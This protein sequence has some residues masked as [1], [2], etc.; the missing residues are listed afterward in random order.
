[1]KST[2]RNFTTA[3]FAWLVSTLLLFAYISIHREG[4]FAES[5]EYFLIFIII[6]CMSVCSVIAFIGLLFLSLLSN[7]FNWSEGKDYLAKI[8]F[9]ASLYLPLYFLTKEFQLNEFWYWSLAGTLAVITFD[10]KHLFTK[11]FSIKN[12]QIQTQ[13]IN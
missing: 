2:I 9:S 12:K 3:F 10:Y 8:L 5:R 13:N 7:I 6:V 1:M 4:N 11:H